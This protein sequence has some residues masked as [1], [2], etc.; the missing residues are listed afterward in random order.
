[1]KTNARRTCIGAFYDDD[2][3]QCAACS[4]AHD[5]D[6]GFLAVAKDGL[7][8]ATPDGYWYHG[9]SRVFR[10]QR[11]LGQGTFA[12]VLA[13]TEEWPSGT[14]SS[15]SS[16]LS[17]RAHLNVSLLA[18][19]NRI[20]L[21][22]NQY[23]IKVVRAVPK[24]R[25]AARTEIEILRD[26]GTARPRNAGC[27]QLLAVFEFRHH[28][29][30]LFPLLAIDLLGHLEGRA[31][32][33]LALADVRLL[34]RQLL[35]ALAFLRNRHVIHTDLKPENVMFVESPSR[36]RGL[37]RRP[38]SVLLIDFGS[39]IYASRLHPDI[40]S[41]RHYRAPE[42][43][44]GLEWSFPIDMWS[45]GCLLVE[46][47]VGRQVFS[48]HANVEHLAM[49]AKFL[50]VQLLPLWMLQEHTRNVQRRLSQA[51]V[52]KPT[53]SLSAA[54]RRDS[55]SEVLVLPDGRIPVSQ[56]SAYQALVPL[57]QLLSSSSED[58]TFLDL[59]LGMLCIDPKRRI[60]PDQALLHPFIV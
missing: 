22:R 4:A 27:I 48:T 41:T 18:F 19:G 60:T 45:L 58:P 11:L 32:R 50:D 44:L 25:R 49:I 52:T 57:R 17:S 3:L 26:L 56:S 1:M 39:A 8:V 12:T 20:P 23:A 7:I 38:P 21:S 59:I 37:G 42:I 51:A 31:F 5:D 6:D 47:V 35:H 24:Y 33:G 43:I 53:L 36:V 15:T 46:L 55:L 28:V 40:I 9:K 13:A 10:V 30:L 54:R 2:T 29:C 14:P 34:A 16:S